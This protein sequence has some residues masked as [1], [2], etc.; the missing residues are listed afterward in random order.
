MLV[1]EEIE[2]PSGKLVRYTRDLVEECEIWIKKDP[3]L[4]YMPARDPKEWVPFSLEEL[5][6]NIFLSFFII[7]DEKGIMVGIIHC[8]VSRVL[9]DEIYDRPDL[10][11]VDDGLINIVMTESYIS[12]T[13]L[14]TEAVSEIMKFVKSKFPDIFCFSTDIYRK[15]KTLFD[16]YTSLGFKEARRCESPGPRAFLIKK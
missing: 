10:E 14:P 15:E 4:R 8:N 7:R 2:L 13:S 5:T 16:V 11:Y 1:P 12:E 3:Y 6:K 9:W